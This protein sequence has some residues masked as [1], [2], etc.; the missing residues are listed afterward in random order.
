MAGFYLN[1]SHKNKIKSSF[2]DI[3]AVPIAKRIQEI[4]T[5]K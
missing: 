2:I 3:F 4:K 5:I 1:L